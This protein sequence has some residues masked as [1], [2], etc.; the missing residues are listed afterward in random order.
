MLARQSSVE[1]RKACAE[2]VIAY[3]SQFLELL[4]LSSYLFMV[5]TARVSF[6]EISLR[7]FV[8]IDNLKVLEAFC[9][10][11]ANPHLRILC[12]IFCNVSME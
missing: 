7:C 1:V 4:C 8:V 10:Q 6:D 2:Q 12:Q 3:Y 11:V 9:C 5:I